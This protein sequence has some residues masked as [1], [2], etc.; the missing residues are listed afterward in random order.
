[1]LA[2]SNIQRIVQE[3]GFEAV[4]LSFNSPSATSMSMIEVEK[5]ILYALIMALNYPKLNL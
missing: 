3:F 2:L 4:V 5:F 1:M